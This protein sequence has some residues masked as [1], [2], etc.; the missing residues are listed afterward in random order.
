MESKSELLQ[1][2]NFTSYSVNY[3]FINYTNFIAIVSVIIY[4]IIIITASSIA[5]SMNMC[6]VQDSK[7]QC[8]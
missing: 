2:V 7:L 5:T 4:D 1:A 3:S 6:L 8:L